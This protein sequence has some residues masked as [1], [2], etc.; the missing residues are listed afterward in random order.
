MRYVLRP[1]QNLR[2]HQLFLA[3]VTVLIAFVIPLTVYVLQQQQ[4]FKEY[5]GMM[6][7]GIVD[8]CKINNVNATEQM[9]FCDQFIVPAKGANRG[10]GGDLDSTRWSFNRLTQD[11]NSGAIND[12][13]PSEAQFCRIKKI[14]VPDNDSFICGLEF[15][16]PNHWME[17][18]ND[19]GNY[20]MNSARITQP[21]DF[22]GRTGIISFDVDAHSLG[23]HDVWPEVWITEEPMQ[24]PHLD[25]PATHQFPKKAVGF[26][27]N[28]DCGDQTGKSNSLSD[29]EIF[30]NYV[31]N[32]LDVDQCDPNSIFTTE[33][34]NA[35][36]F[37]IHISQ[38]SIEFWG[39]NAGGGNFRKL[40]AFNNLAIPFTRGYVHFQHA[41]YNAAKFGPINTGTFHWHA[42]GFDGPVLPAD[43]TYEVPDSL[44]KSDNNINI[45]Y[46]TPF[47]YTFHNVDL[48]NAKQ[49]YLALNTYYF[50]NTPSIA[51]TINGSQHTYS[52]AM[53]SPGGFQWNYVQIPLNLAELKQGANSI[54]INTSGNCNYGCTILANIDLDI[55]LQENAPFTKFMNPPVPCVTAYPGFIAASCNGTPMPSMVM[56]T[57]TPVPTVL[58]TPTLRPTSTPI[59]TQPAKGGVLGNN[60]QGSLDD[61]SDANFMDGSLF[62]MGN[63]TKTT[64]VMSV[65]VGTIESSPHNQYQVAIYSDKNGNPKQLITRSSIGVLKANS[66]NTIA[67]AA[68][69]QAGKSYWFMYNTNGTDISMNNM[70]YNINDSN[71]IAW[72]LKEQPF[73]IWPAKFGAVSKQQGLFSIYVVFQ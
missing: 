35:N 73:G 55:V 38:T 4:H 8:N 28:A 11:V 49:A 45:G 27:I 58:P 25:H 67:I 63:R 36:H 68:T 17:S 48:S 39:S 41:Q 19:D 18:M 59:P 57:M 64:S 6:M 52:N 29:I 9:A 3:I 51:Y 33:P 13:A 2:P 65:Y 47:D 31:A 37:E 32:S 44:T 70:K 62:A 10:R 12:F 56:P 1:L 34:D 14:V 15:G 21:F 7:G 43:R 24:G 54:T 53:S 23:P 42:L 66:W 26:I 16:E 20:V 22:S 69:L 40:Q 61:S 5:A 46:I 72:S 50:D 60:I 71:R 30:N